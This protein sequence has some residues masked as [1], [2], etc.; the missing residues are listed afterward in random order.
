MLRSPAFRR[1]TAP[2]AVLLPLALLAA[3]CSGG[4]AATGGSAG[5]G[6]STGTGG[7]VGAPDSTPPTVLSSHP[8][9]A[10]VGESTAVTI[11]ATFS[12]RMAPLTLTSATFSLKQGAVVVPGAVSYF[13]TTATFSPDKDLAL[14]TT[15]TATITTAA[16]DVAGNALAATYTW[17][18]TTGTTAPAGPAPVL[19]GAAGDYAILAKSAI[20]NVPTSVVTG[21]LG[22]SPAAASYLTGFSLTRAGTKWTS[23]QVIGGVFAADNDPP[24]PTDLTTAVANM[25]TAY[26]DAAGRPTPAFLELGGGAIGGLTLAPGLYKWTS[27]V[28]VPSDIT[29]SGAPN[30][31]WIFQITGDLQMSAATSMTLSGGA[32]AK[33][34]VWQVAGLVDLGTTSHAE[35]IMLSQTAINLGTGASIN[36]RLLAQTAVHL[37]GATVTAPAP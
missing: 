22:L 18:F 27:T 31:V 13:N 7:A 35:G 1:Y 17:S 32:R 34:I 28:T 6:S 19:L 33:N 11:S 36:G 29:I 24:T 23:T 12:E 25:Q 37:A 8:L 3:A 9:D 20:S 2:L 30:D 16:T 10:A 15:Y 21:D 5:T 26:T 14:G 4:S